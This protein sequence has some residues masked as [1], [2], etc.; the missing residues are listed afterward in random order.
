MSI[1]P[2]VGTCQ[3]DMQLHSQK[4]MRQAELTE[5]VSAHRLHKYSQERGQGVPNFRGR[6]G[7]QEPGEQFEKE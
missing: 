3:I 5:G 2:P 1:T 7:E 6:R 4:A